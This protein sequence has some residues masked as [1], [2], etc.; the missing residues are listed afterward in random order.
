MKSPCWA[1]NPGLLRTY[2]LLS[3]SSASSSRK[4]F[5]HSTLILADS[6]PSSVSF[7]CHRSSQ[8]PGNA[9]AEV[10][11]RKRLRPPKPFQMSAKCTESRRVPGIVAKTGSLAVYLWHANCSGIYQFSRNA[12]RNREMTITALCKAIW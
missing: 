5:Q 1:G 3:T 11:I 12:R 6:G 7:I 8:G 2:R 10:H 9:W 4:D